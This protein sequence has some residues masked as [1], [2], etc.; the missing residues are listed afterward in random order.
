MCFF[1]KGDLSDLLTGDI[2]DEDSL[3]DLVAANISENADDD[4]EIT[5]DSSMQELYEGNINF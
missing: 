3:S 4:D 5:L 1:L 2:S